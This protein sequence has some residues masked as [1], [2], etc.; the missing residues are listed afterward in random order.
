MPFSRLEAEKRDRIRELKGPTYIIRRLMR[1]D[2]L[3]VKFKRF[4]MLIFNGIILEKL[5]V[6]D[7]FIFVEMVENGSSW[8]SR[9]QFK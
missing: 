4:S 3:L 1:V 9:Y 5:N 2:F 6:Q 8:I 7:S